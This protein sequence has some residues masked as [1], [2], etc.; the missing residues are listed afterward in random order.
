MYAKVIKRKKMLGVYRKEGAQIAR[1]LN[2]MEAP[3]AL[4]EQEK[5]RILKEMRDSVDRKV[6]CE[7]A[8]INKTVS[9]A[10]KQIE[11]ITY[12]RDTVGFEHLPENLVEAA[13]V[14]L[15]N[16]DATLKELGEAL[17]PPV[18]KSG[19]NHRLRRLSEMAEKARQEQGGLL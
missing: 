1:R 7:T 12:L 6:N 9:A 2:V 5:I 4:R 15:E 19:F 13:Q 8:N 3:I 10:V 18:G 17:D 16:P 14:R 11:D